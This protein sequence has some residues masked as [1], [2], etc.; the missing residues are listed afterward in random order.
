M[1]P[2]MNAKPTD[3]LI[4]TASGHLEA[5]FDEGTGATRAIVLCHPHP[6]YGGSMHDA[7]VGT[8]ESVARR[9][10]FATLRFNFRGVG[11]STGRY[12]NGI[13]EVDDLLCALAWLRDRVGTMP[14]WLAGYSFGSNVVWRAIERAGD[15]GGVV[16][17][18]PPVAMMDFSARPVAKAPVTLIAGDEDDYVDAADLRRWAAEAAGSARVEIIAGADHFFSGGHTDLAKAAERAFAAR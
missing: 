14:I 18:A 8:V 11:D 6:Q 17:V 4:P 3:L 5:C 9:H 1:F 13:G 12:D 10:A 15:V 7:V 2:P 16:L